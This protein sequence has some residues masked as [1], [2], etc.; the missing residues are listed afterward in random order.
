MKTQV[1]AAVGFL[2]LMFG[3]QNCS[4]SGSESQNSSV[5][6]QQAKI[7]DPNLKSLQSLEILT[8]AE[9]QSVSLNIMTG[10]LVQKGAM[11]TVRKCLSAERLATIQDLLQK[12]S[13]C[14]FEPAEGELCAHVYGYPY[15]ILQWPDI[16]VQVG[17]SHSSCHKGPDLCGQDG[18]L[19]RGLLRDVIARWSEWSCD[20][21]SL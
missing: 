11:G 4:Q 9:G 20:F 14:E 1:A 13:L 6:T 7:E 15:A 17:E 12:S 19:L 21:Q 3:F 2:V 8:T 18:K 10:E 16:Q 5:P